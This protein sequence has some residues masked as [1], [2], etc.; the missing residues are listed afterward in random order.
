MSYASGHPVHCA[1]QGD[2]CEAQ[3]PGSK[4]AAIKAGDEGWFFS[5]KDDAAYCPEHVPDWVPAWR[6]AA[7]R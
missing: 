5:R 7:P 1:R 3:I 2:G 6:A 4:W